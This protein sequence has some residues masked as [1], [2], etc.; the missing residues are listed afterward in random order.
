MPTI[1]RRIA[2]IA[3][4]TADA[5][6]SSMGA[7]VCKRTAESGWGL[8]RL[9]RDRWA[10]QKWWG[11]NLP[12][13]GSH[14]WFG[15]SPCRPVLLAGHFRARQLPA[16]DSAPGPEP[17]RGLGMNPSSGRVETSPQNVTILAQTPWLRP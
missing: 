10:H 4:A 15:A 12:R 13:P 6:T 16:L 5:A 3:T 8:D 11:T 9:A 17:V 2:T 7:C 14:C 1:V